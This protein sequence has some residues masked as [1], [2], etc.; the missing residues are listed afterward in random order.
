MNEAIKHTAEV[1]R[2]R[3]KTSDPFILS[4]KLN[5]EVNWVE[6]GDHP[7]GKISYFPDG[8]PFIM[9]NNKIRDNPLRYFT[10]AHELGHI[11]FQEGLVGY[12]KES[13][14]GENHMERE[15]DKFAASLLGLLYIEENGRQP[16][17]WF[18]LV[19]AYGFPSI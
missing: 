2:D 8:A 18:D 1:L 12:Y 19:H 9:M 11:I 4:E 3:Y 16:S 5:V 14:F 13:A 15:A 7:L 6:L 10:L 17:N